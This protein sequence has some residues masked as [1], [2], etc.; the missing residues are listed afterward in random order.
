MCLNNAWV[1]L[2]CALWIPEVLIGDFG[3]KE[4]IKNIENID[5]KRF[6]EECRICT[7]KG[8]GPTLKCEN[9]KCHTYFHVECAR[10][11]KYQLEL[12]NNS[13]GEVKILKNNIIL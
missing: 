6:L 8:Y 11:N 10:I 4:E 1:H 7:M 13:N 3:K 12:V 2:S 9:I 5:K